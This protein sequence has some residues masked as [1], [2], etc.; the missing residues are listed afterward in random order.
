LKVL[1]SDPFTKSLA[2]PYIL[3]SPYFFLPIRKGG[4]FLEVWKFPPSPASLSRRRESILPEQPL[5][6]VPFF[7]SFYFQIFFNRRPSSL[8]GDSFRGLEVTGRT[9]LRAPCIHLLAKQLPTIWQV[10]D[11]ELRQVPPNKLQLAPTYFFV[12]MNHG[13][14]FSLWR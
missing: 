13:L 14:P 2:A 8:S 5:N 1:F 9:H 11:S 3:F 4:T 6:N 12:L 10:Y 7:F